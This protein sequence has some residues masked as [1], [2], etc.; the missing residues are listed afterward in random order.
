MAEV[1]LYPL[2]DYEIDCVFFLLVC[3]I[4][5]YFLC[6]SKSGGCS[7]M[8]ALSVLSFFPN[9][10]CHFFLN[11]SVKYKYPHGFGGTGP[12]TLIKNV[13]ENNCM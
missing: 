11:V 12:S 1:S 6:K 9:V 7:I 3:A 5:I 8:L 2:K 4:C 10:L 13:K